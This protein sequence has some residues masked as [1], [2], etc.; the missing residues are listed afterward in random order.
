MNISLCQERR[1]GCAL[2]AV[3]CWLAVAPANLSRW[4][5]PPVMAQPGVVPAHGLIRFP[6][7]S[8][9]QRTAIRKALVLSQQAEFCRLP[10]ALRVTHG[11]LQDVVAHIEAAAPRHCPIEVRANSAARFTLSL[12]NASVGD[13]LEAAAKLAD[14]EVYT[15]SDHLLLAAPSQ[16]S[17]TEQTEL[18]QGK[19]QKG[20]DNL[21]AEL[22]SHAYSQGIHLFLDIIPATLLTYG[23][24]K[25]AANLGVI[26]PG[27]QL[28][29]GEISPELQQMIQQLVVWTVQNSNKMLPGAG[30]MQIPRLTP[31]ALV[32]FSADGTT[33]T[34]AIA[35][36]SAQRVSFKWI[37]TY[38]GG[39]Y[40]M[41]T[42]LGGLPRL[43]P[44][45]R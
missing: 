5:L 41:R 25:T 10:I 37:G 16:L 43:P 32:S 2:V 38:S 4:L 24:S 18:Q 13:I 23:A 30:I 1:L 15:F 36:T 19:A 14:C 8:A 3:T 12:A 42:F 40:D 20:N 39:G 31:D 33:N 11:T 9:D 17:A 34:L 27:G 26:A 22:E 21:E 45:Q 6:P 28:A 44:I 29:L 35:M 7:L